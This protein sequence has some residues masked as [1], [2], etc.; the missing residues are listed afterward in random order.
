MR[1]DISDH[2]VARVIQDKMYLVPTAGTISRQGAIVELNSTAREIWE[3]MATSKT[4]TKD[5]VTVHLQK[6][7]GKG[8]EVK[9]DVA[10]FWDFLSENE[11]ISSV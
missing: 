4:F 10:E 1:A 5:D 9:T 8:V 7:Y 3:F 11:L 6:K 2:V